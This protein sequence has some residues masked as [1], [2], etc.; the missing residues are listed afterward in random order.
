MEE[1]MID[2]LYLFIV[3]LFFAACF[4]MIKGLERL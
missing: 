4:A 2:L 1:N 3:I